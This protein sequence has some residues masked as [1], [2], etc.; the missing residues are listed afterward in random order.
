MATASEAN[1]VLM[2]QDFLKENTV[3]LDWKIYRV[4]FVLIFRNCW[5]F[6]VVWLQLPFLWLFFFIL[7][8]LLCFHDTNANVCWTNCW[9][10]TDNMD[11]QWAYWGFKF[12]WTTIYLNQ[13]RLSLLQI[14]VF[15]WSLFKFQFFF[16]FFLCLHSV[17]WASKMMFCIWRKNLHWST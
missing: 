10:S 14:T 7:L 15:K 6:Y 1:A 11:D 9:R 16:Y 13:N 12:C 8:R 17:F 2:V 5:D 3:V 4:I